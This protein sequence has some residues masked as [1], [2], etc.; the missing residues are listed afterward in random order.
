MR[1]Q[2]KQTKK[3]N[4]GNRITEKRTKRGVLILFFNALFLSLSVEHRVGR[5]LDARSLAA[6]MNYSKCPCKMSLEAKGD[7]RW[8]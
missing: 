3:T 6:T 8:D 7:E 2:K 5:D 4:S 1:S